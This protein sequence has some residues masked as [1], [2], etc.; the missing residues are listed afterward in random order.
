VDCS[1][2]EPQLRRVRWRCRRGIKELDLLLERFC[3]TQLPGA[4]AAERDE[5]EALLGLPDPLL[6][7]YLLGGLTPQGAALARLMSRIRSYVA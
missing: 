2:T 4:S 7:E 1:D 3:R 5:F 6:A